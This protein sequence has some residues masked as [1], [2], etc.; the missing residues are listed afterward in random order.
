MTEPLPILPAIHAAQQ[1]AGIPSGRA[2]AQTSY[3]ATSGG[4]WIKLV[5]EFV[6]SLQYGE[7]HLSVHKGRVVE[8]R[9]MEKVRF[10]E[11]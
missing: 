11:S 3:C 1:A 10:D 7:I 5:K 9:K 4:Q 6:K 2:V 8:V